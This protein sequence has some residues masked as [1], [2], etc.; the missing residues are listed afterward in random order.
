[1]LDDLPSAPKHSAAAVEETA[2][3]EEES[4]IDISGDE[5]EEP[6]SK[7]ASEVEEDWGL[8]D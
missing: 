3:D 5:A 8:W 1:M 2:N 4:D 7:G 6:E